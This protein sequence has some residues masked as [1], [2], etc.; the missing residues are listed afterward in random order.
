M[1][2]G[3]GWLN[4]SRLAAVDSFLMPD[5]LRYTLDSAGNYGAPLLL[6]LLSCWLAWRR[7]GDGPFWLGRWTAAF[8]TLSVGGL[9]LADHWTGREDIALIGRWWPALFIL[10]G[11]ELFMLTLRR[12]RQE[13]KPSADVSG[14]ATAIVIAVT[15]YGVTQ[16]AELPYRWLDQWAAERSGYGDYGEEKGFSYVKPVVSAAPT[17]DLERIVIDNPNGKVR[18]ERGGVDTIVVESTVWIDSGDHTEAD[19]AAE[20]TETVL[21]AGEE[22][23]IKTIAAGF[24]GNGQR[25]PRVNLVVYLPP[26]IADAAPSVPTAPELPAMTTSTPPSDADI[27]SNK[28]IDEETPNADEEIAVK[29]PLDIQVTIVSGDVNVSQLT[30]PINLTLSVSD[31]QVLASG[32]A[33][34]VSAKMVNGNVQLRDIQGDVDVSARNG[35]IEVARASANVN[36]STS[37]GSIH[38]NQVQGDLEADTKNG[39]IKIQEAN[40]SVKA[41][42]LNGTIE[43]SSAMV[44]GDWDIVGLVGDVRLKL[45]VHGSYEM[46]G[47]ATFGTIK[48]EPGLPL[49]VNKK[50]VRGT[51]GTGQH[52]VY[53]NANSNIVI[54]PFA[55]Q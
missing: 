21:T 41:D 37:N 16:Y 14:V 18:I 19:A 47:S 28:P 24:G 17:A 36:A 15:A 8:F 23:T 44:G 48:V 3:S 11:F 31:G 38:L 34:L 46:N 33:G 13:R 4:G 12:N 43:A 26:S 27:H 52:R 42:T 49:E 45:P 1:A 32:I 30:A 7:R 39:G 10:L 5:E 40:G 54:S 29:P 55:A 35:S 2:V 53:V 51:I 6:L 25:K 9:L 22:T 50:T 20:R